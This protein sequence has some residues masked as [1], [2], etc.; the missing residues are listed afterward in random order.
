VFFFDRPTYLSREGTFPHWFLIYLS[1]NNKKYNKDIN[2][3][4]TPAVYYL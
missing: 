2:L 3:Y 1:T 4:T